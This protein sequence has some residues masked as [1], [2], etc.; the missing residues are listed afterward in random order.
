MGV[1]D[2]DGGGRAAN[3]GKIVEAGMVARAVRG[4]FFGI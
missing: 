2:G 1:L 3:P 4:Q